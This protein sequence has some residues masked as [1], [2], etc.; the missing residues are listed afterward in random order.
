MRVGRTADAASSLQSSLAVLSKESTRTWV[1]AGVE[2][3]DLHQKLSALVGSSGCGSSRVTETET[4][5]GFA[6]ENLDSA[7]GATGVSLRKSRGPGQ[8]EG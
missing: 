5:F 8:G 2:P 4:F 1:G 6:R 3:E 7:G